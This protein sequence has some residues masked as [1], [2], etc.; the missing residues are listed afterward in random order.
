MVRL[1]ALL[2]L[3][4][5]LMRGGR[6]LQHCCGLAGNQ[7]RHH[8]DL[9]A[10]KFQRVMMDVRVVHIDLAESGHAMLNLG[11]AKHAEGAVELDL[12]VESELRAREQ[13]DRDVGLT[14]FGEAACDRL[15]EIGGNEPVRDLRW[16]GGDKM[17]TIITQGE[18]TPLEGRV[19]ALFL[20]NPALVQ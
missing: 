20:L 5:A 1:R 4:A 3:A 13:A 2:L 11:F 8:Y 15:Y 12:F 14:D 7:P 16:P 18:R 6:Q 17:Q 19:P 10:G 9:A